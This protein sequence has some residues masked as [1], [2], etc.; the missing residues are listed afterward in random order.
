MVFGTLFLDAPM[1]GSET[2]WSSAVHGDGLAAR[3]ATKIRA[4]A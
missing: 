1:L 2:G 3:H 4:N